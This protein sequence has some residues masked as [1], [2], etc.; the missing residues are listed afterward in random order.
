MTCVAAPSSS[1]NNNDFVGC[2]GGA[3]PV[4][5]GALNC[6][7][8]G[9]PGEARWERAVHCTRGCR[10]L[11]I[12]TW[13]VGASC[14]HRNIIASRHS[15]PQ[16]TPPLQRT[17]AAGRHKKVAACLLSFLPLSFSRKT[18]YKTT[19]TTLH[20]LVSNPIERVP[21]VYMPS[22][23]GA[24][25]GIGVKN[26]ICLDTTIVFSPSQNQRLSQQQTLASS[27]FSFS[28]FA[29]NNHHGQCCWGWSCKWRC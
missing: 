23:A 15:P 13:A 2:G 4:L 28:P 6:G 10:G 5:C 26:S 20:F 11:A 3:A 17:G 22:A 29:N 9:R 12:C 25:A 27:S 1:P 21:L 14:R 19:T 18:K 16:G 8:L 7:L 24:G